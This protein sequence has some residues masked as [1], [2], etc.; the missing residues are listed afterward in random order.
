MA[1]S[2]IL[3]L[4]SHM[5]AFRTEYKLYVPILKYTWLYFAIKLSHPGFEAAFY[6]PISN[7]TGIIRTLLGKK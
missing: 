2:Y 4:I 6:L 3:F 5:C 7:I 1:S